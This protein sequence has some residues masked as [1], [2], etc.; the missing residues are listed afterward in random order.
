MFGFFYG[1]RYLFYSFCQFPSN[2]YIRIIFTHIT[3]NALRTR[4]SLVLFDKIVTIVYKN[5]HLVKRQVVEADADEAFVEVEGKARPP[6]RKIW[7][8]QQKCAHD[9]LAETPT[10]TRHFIIHTTSTLPKFCFDNA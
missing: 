5:T 2:L 6:L 10:A 1:V 9:A 4:K 8:Q 7:P 3:I